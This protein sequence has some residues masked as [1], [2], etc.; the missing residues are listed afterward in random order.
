[1]I[2]GNEKGSIYVPS[3]KLLLPPAPAVP[4]PVPPL[5][6]QLPL[7]QPPFPPPPPIIVVVII[8]IIIII[9]IMFPTYLITVYLTML[10][11]RFT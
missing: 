2:D 8:I 1:M 10:L 5:T 9:I 4:A 7:L 11:T 3:V 6:L